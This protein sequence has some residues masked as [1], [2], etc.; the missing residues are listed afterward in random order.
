LF[1]FIDQVEDLREI[2]IT[3]EQADELIEKAQIIINSIQI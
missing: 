2:K 1:D 3:N